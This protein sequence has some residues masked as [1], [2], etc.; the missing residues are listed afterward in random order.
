M[1]DLLDGYPATVVKG[2][3]AASQVN[4]RRAMAEQTAAVAVA[5][6]AAL[7]L[8]FNQGKGRVLEKWVEEMTE[9]PSTGKT[10]MS[11]RAFS[12]FSSLPRKRG[13]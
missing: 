4:R 11:E 10:G 8:V 1:E 3:L 9:S 13:G 5:V 12:F 2:M 6:S 7:D